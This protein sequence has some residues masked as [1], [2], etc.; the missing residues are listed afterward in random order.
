VSCPNRKRS[1]FNFLR[2]EPPQARD[3]WLT[4]ASLLG[5]GQSPILRLESIVRTI[6]R[7]PVFTHYPHYG[8]QGGSPGSVIRKDDWKL[9]EGFEERRPV[10]L[11]NLSADLGE[12][13][14]WRP[15]VEVVACL[16]SKNLAAKL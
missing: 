5:K 3:I 6:C 9:I 13:N 11:Y 2:Y 16:L 7:G 12:R 14:N 4:N 8:N 15:A 1:Y 10:A